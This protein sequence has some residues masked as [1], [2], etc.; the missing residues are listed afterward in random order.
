MMQTI[1]GEPHRPINP[2]VLSIPAVYFHMQILNFSQGVYTPDHAS[3]NPS[4]QT[5]LRSI[6]QAKA[7]SYV[8]FLQISLLEAD[9]SELR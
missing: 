4:W 2:S 8:I 9:A 6:M 7:S 5:A 1:L 3:P